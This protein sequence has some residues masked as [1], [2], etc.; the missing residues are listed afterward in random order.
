MNSCFFYNTDISFIVSCTRE[1]NEKGSENKMRTLFF[2]FLGNES[3]VCSDDSTDM[4]TA[5]LE[6]LK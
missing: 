2:L 6:H 1:K 3:A 5:F 4:K